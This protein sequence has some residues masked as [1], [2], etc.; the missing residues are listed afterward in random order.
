MIHY[1]FFASPIGL[2]HI[3][4][5][6]A[7]AENL[8]AKLDFITGSS[9]AGM[10]KE[11]D[12]SVQ[13]R[14]TPPSFAVEKGTLKNSTRWLWSYY[15]YYKDCK[16][17]ARDILQTRPDLVLSDED[18]AAL[19][20]AQE[21]NI[22]TILITDILETRF[23]SG[24][25]RIIEKRMNRTMHNIMERCD[26]IIM[27]ETG[28]NTGNIKRVGPIVRDTPKTREQLREEFKLQNTTLVITV[29]GTDLGRHLIQKTLDAVSEINYDLDVV[30]VSGPAIKN[31]DKV[32][33]LGFV[34]NMHELIFAADLIISLAG[35][36]TIDETIAYGTPGIFIP[37]KDHFEQED[38]A[39]RYGFAADDIS[40]LAELIPIGL[41]K[42]RLPK[43]TDGAKRAADIIAKRSN[44]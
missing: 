9:A 8:D 2:G 25:A 43:D 22:P 6:I 24:I 14:Y 32:R 3:T 40:K 16:E 41:E 4:R 11:T 28:P 44:A 26:T 34:H 21:Q 39:R 37:I 30:L 35:R 1:D 19:V 36:S 27:P 31:F 29:G 23:T 20:V 38:N 10:L 5:D 12:W 33:D 7:I 15:Q 18:F 17:I 42:K 13:D